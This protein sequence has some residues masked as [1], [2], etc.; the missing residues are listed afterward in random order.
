MGVSLSPPLF[1]LLESCLEMLTLRASGFLSF[2]PHSFLLLPALYCD[3]L[4]GE[5]SNEAFRIVEGSVGKQK[6]YFMG[7]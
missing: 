1:S 4:L 7:R 2:M 3:S 6:G 5:S